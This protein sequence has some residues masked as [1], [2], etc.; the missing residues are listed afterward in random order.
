MAERYS[1]T[2]EGMVVQQAGGGKVRRSILLSL[3]VSLLL[4]ACSVGQAQ[5]VVEADHNN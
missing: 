2:P 3:L 1:R 5:I 4:A